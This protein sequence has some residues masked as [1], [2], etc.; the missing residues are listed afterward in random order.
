M[1][2]QF[3]LLAETTVAISPCGGV[4]ISSVALAYVLQL[5]MVQCVIVGVRLGAEPHHSDHRRESLQA[6]QLTLAN[7][8]APLLLQERHGTTAPRR[9]GAYY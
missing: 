1:A 8:Y 9:A 2:E 5:E 6:L 4:S 3:R 7:L